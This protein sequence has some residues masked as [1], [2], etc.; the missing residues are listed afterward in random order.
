MEVIRDATWEQCLAGAA[1]MYRLDEPDDRC[2][3]L[4][5]ATWKCKMSYKKHEQKKADRKLIVLD[6]PPEVCVTSRTHA[7]T[8][9]AT[10]MSGKPCSFKAVCGDFC[11]KHR[12][13][14]APLGKKVQI[15]S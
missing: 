4:A 15:K 14:K 10:T 13:D 7:K 11:K 6:R 9:Q 12:I 1:K 8:C 3:H 5:D 2:Y